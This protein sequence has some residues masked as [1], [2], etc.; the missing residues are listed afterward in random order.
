LWFAMSPSTVQSRFYHRIGLNKVGG[1]QAGLVS[2]QL[3]TLRG[4]PNF[5]HSRACLK[6]ARPPSK[7]VRER[8]CGIAIISKQLHN[9]E[10]NL[11]R[12]S[13]QRQ[14]GV[15][16][17]LHVYALLLQ[18]LDAS[19]K[20]LEMHGVYERSSA[21]RGLRFYVRHSALSMDA[22]KET[23]E[24]RERNVRAKWKESCG[25]GACDKKE[26]LVVVGICRASPGKCTLT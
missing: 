13:Q 14:E 8:N 11:V 6:D 5:S 1:S 10:H 23:Q 21:S 26:G 17:T 4:E 7:R 15:P 12:Q 25:D 20:V 9:T 24:R 16:R 22:K 19:V 18:Q 3:L 2:P